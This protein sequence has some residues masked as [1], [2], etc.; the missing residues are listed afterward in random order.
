[1]N[2]IFLASIVGL[3]L[4]LNATPA[5][6]RGIMIVNTGTDILHVD[7]VPADKKAEIE[8]ATQPGVSLGYMYSRFGVFWLDVWRWD[9]KFVLY[10]GDNFWALPDAELAQVMNV[11]S[12]SDISRPWKYR[13]PWGLLVL[14]VIAVGGVAMAIL[15]R[16]KKDHVTTPAT[17]PPAA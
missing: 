2:K 7:E 1:M 16:K 6:A 12:M 9:G 10:S 13:M 14:V 17:A 5:S 11:K 15:G 8:S 4:L 3:V